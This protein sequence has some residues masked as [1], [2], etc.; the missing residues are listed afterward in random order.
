[1][2]LLTTIPLYNKATTIRRAVASVLSQTYSCD[3]LIVNDG[4]TDG[5]EKL[6]NAYCNDPRVNILNQN[7]AGVSVAR[8]VAIDYAI[9]HQY[10]G[11]AFLDADDYWL[12]DH[13]YHILS[14]ASSFPHAGVLSTNYQYL[15]KTG[16]L[17]DTKFSVETRISAV[18]DNYFTY[19]YY[20][21]PL[22]SSNI[23]LRLA[24][25]HN[26]RYNEQVTHGEDTD[27]AI[28]TGINQVVAFNP[29]VSV[30]ID[31]S[32]TNRSGS[33][34]PKQRIY[35]DLDQ[36]RLYQ[37]KQIGLAKYLDL[38]R[39]AI[40]MEFLM[41]DLPEEAEDYINAINAN[42]LSKKQV[43]LLK[44]PGTTLRRMK[45]VQEWLVRR[46]LHL[47]LASR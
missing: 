32:T 35:P 31:V 14:L 5:G 18:L 9:E 26:L 42:H 47:R 27:F 34:S 21:S 6:L 4:S 44:L 46:G 28:K 37:D 23:A 7:N 41:A 25:N 17:H 16:R 2:N 15:G 8:N 10:E 38:N 39:F 12:P 22:T 45:S 40:A 24:V 20:N 19:S 3:L 33:I 11:I 29:A 36:Y 30:V 43:A 1:M 13:I